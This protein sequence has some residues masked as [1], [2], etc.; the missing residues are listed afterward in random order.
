MGALALA[1]MVAAIVL[2][3]WAGEQPRPVP[4]MPDEG[5]NAGD[6]QRR[7]AVTPLKT[8]TGAESLAGS[9]SDY[10]GGSLAGASV[11]AYLDR[12]G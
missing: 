3:R 8:G 6:R 4:Q 10:A 12:L 11:S 5:N 7:T 1:A 2:S 9:V